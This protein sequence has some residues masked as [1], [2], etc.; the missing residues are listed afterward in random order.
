M[1]DA[2]KFSHCLTN[3]RRRIWKLSVRLLTL[4]SKY[5]ISE[6]HSRRRSTE[7][8]EADVK[9]KRFMVM[10]SSINGLKQEIDLVRV[11]RL[12]DSQVA[13]EERA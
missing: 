8:R 5:K 1:N 3:R 9:F 4:R 7:Q 2:S 13:K 11:K 6:L 12:K 10:E